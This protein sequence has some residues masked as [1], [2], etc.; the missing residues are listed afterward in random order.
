LDKLDNQLRFIN[1]IACADLVVCNHTEASLLA[2]LAVRGY[3]ELT[4]QVMKG[5]GTENVANRGY[6]YLLE[7]PIRTFTK[8]RVTALPPPQC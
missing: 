7:L 8:D 6:D 4:E 5:Q 1:E 3:P 2:E